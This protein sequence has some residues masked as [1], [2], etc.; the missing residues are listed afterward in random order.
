MSEEKAQTW[1]MERIHQ[2]IYNARTTAFVIAKVL[3]TGSIKPEEH[4]EWVVVI[5]PLLGELGKFSAE[6]A[7]LLEA[8]EKP[9]E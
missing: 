4:P 2:E 7:K 9:Q 3:E 1:T 5:R 8:G 6:I